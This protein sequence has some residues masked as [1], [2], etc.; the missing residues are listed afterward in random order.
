MDVGFMVKVFGIWD[1]GFGVKGSEL[2]IWD[3][4]FSCLGLKF[5][6]SALGFVV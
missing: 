1:F 4:E 2:W 5:G 6:V 3:L